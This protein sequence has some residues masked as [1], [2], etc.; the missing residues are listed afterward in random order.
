MSTLNFEVGD[1]VRVRDDLVVGK[2]YDNESFVENMEKFK[3]Q[4]CTISEKFTCGIY[5]L[6]ED[7]EH[8][9]FSDEMLEKVENESKEKE[10][11]IVKCLH[12]NYQL[13]T[14]NGAY[15]FKTNDNVEKGDYVYCDTCYGL[16]ICVVAKIYTKVEEII[17]LK[18]MPNISYLKECRLNLEE[19]K[20]NE[21]K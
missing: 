18:D 17:N 20:R 19:V 6:E 7:E 14:T 2:V 9:A 5:F 15:Y 8:W 16:M 13:K 11:K 21:E 3:G 12:V 4:I 1:K 10:I